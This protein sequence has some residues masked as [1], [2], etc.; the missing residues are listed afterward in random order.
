MT[1]W[2]KVL[3]YDLTTD[4]GSGHL[5]IQCARPR[6]DFETAV[7]SN[8]VGGAAAGPSAARAHE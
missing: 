4:D 1:K 5:L 7:A 3:R 6:R 8:E 2:D